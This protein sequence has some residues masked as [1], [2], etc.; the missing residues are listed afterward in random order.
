MHNSENFQESV[1][2]SNFKSNFL[3]L[4]PYPSTHTVASSSSNH[5]HS[6]FTYDFACFIFIQSPGMGTDLIEKLKFKGV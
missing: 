3:S 5:I 2:I 6:N 4:W 1:V